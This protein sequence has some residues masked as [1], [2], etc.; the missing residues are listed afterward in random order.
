MSADYNSILIAG[1]ELE[2]KEVSVFVTRYNEKTGVAYQKEY[3]E[4]RLFIL[5]TNISI[6]RSTDRGA[7]GGFFPW[8]RGV[9]QDYLAYFEDHEEGLFFGCVIES[10]TDRKGWYSKAINP[11]E[12]LSRLESSATQIKEQTGYSGEVKLFIYTSVS[13]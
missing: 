10:S 12:I 4:D 6:E 5:G 9:Y 3:R 8:E 11:A 1:V 13:I 2:R 7:N